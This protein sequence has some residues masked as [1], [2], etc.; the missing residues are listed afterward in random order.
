MAASAVNFG[1]NFV[2]PLQQFIFVFF[3]QL[4]LAMITAVNRIVVQFDFFFKPNNI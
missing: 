4:I 1:L 2:Y 3:V